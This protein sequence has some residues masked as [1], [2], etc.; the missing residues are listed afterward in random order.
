MISFTIVENILNVFLF[1]PVALYKS[2]LMWFPEFTQKS[3]DV[4]HEYINQIAVIKG[5]QES[6]YRVSACLSS[7][8]D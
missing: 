6:W 7:L 1:M 3:M 8:F 5:I 2:N 4:H